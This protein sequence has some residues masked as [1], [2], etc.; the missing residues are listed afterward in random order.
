MDLNIWTEHVPIVQAGDPTY[1]PCLRGILVL[2]AGDLS[3][4]T[5]HGETVTVTLE[6]NTFVPFYIR[7]I[8]GTATTIDDA[9]LL[10]GR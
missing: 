5:D 9:D 3:F 7:Q 1:S 4:A 2:A 10:A 6:A 8:F